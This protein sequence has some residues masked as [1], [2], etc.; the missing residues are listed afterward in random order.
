MLMRTKRFQ[1]FILTAV[2]LVAVAGAIALPVYA[3]QDA[4][5]LQNDADMVIQLINQMRVAGGLNALT[6]NPI[7]MQVAQA[8]A[9]Y[10]A[11]SG[12]I[13]HYSADGTR[14]FQRA[15]NAGYWV[16][17]DL[18]RNGWFSENIIG[19]PGMTP[20]RAVKAWTGDAPHLNTMMGP[21]YQDIGVGIASDGESW[22]Y[23][24]DT[25]KPSSVPVAYTPEAKVESSSASGYIIPVK[26]ATPMVDGSIYHQVQSG[27]SLWAVSEAYKVDMNQIASLNGRLGSEQIYIGEKLL[28]R[29]AF[30]LTP[31]PPF[32]TDVVRTPTAT[33]VAPT[34]TPG[35]A[36]AEPLPEK[37]VGYWVVLPVVVVAMAILVGILRAGLNPP[38]DRRKP[39]L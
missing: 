3:G 18:S 31:L 7:L 23:T 12:L 15:L 24:V 32:P 39:P 9:E 35:E 5:P 1:R 29:A 6:P 30:T 14:P 37:D 13:T 20:E 28:I 25:S 8:H 33:H 26:A 19:G 11:A 16:A 10:Q 38:S 22:Y 17:G 36:Q 34:A 2:L 4:A 21:N 27:Q